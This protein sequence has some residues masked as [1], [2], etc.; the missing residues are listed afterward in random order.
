VPGL[1]NGLDVCF[2]IVPAADRPSPSPQEYRPDLSWAFF[3]LVF[4]L[5]EG[6][7]QLSGRAV[8]QGCRKDT[9][10]LPRFDVHHFT[11]S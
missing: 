11:Q 2:S 10:T 1:A 5:A 9:V 4:Q 6:S 7:Y 3:L 8:T